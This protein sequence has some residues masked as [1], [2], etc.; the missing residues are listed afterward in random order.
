M[1][2]RIA[3]GF[4]FTAVAA[5]A[6]CSGADRAGSPGN[7]PDVA[8]GPAPSY[9]EVA[10]RYNERVEPLK[11][12]WSR[13]V[14]RV[15]FPD[16]EGEERTEQ[17][18]GHL[19][20]IRPDRVDL[21]L[22]KVG[23]PVAALGCNAEK[24]WWIELGEGQGR[25]AYVGSHSMV[26]P[27][28]IAE[29]GL[30]VYPLD[31]IELIG[32]TPLPLEAREQGVEAP[33]VRWSPNGRELVLNLPQRE[34]IRRMILDPETLDPIRIEVADTSGRTV[35]SSELTEYQ[36]V[37]MRGGLPGT[38]RARVPGEILATVNE[39]RTRVRMRIYDPE[40]GG[41]RPKPAAFELP[42]LLDVYSIQ[43]VINLDE[44]PVA[45]R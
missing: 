15:W 8:R 23:H 19:Q 45:L 17:V 43:T 35:L 10:R 14:F 21:T 42:R 39:G 30:P 13:T 41:S 37:A 36:T 28:R 29:L 44:Q 7:A 20:Y 5:I 22:R 2:L 11:S 38:A 9:E 34:G 1:M 24:Y 31:L 33:A 3:A 26:D 4:C 12:L 18:E 40:T 16:R 27:D 25:K 32:I 6:G